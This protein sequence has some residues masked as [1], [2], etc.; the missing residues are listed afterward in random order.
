[1]KEYKDLHALVAQNQDANKFYNAL[2]DYVREHIATRAQ[3]VRSLET[4]QSF[5][6]NYMSG[7]K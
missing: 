5:A 1:M 4:L 7:D 2:P 6:D 3:N